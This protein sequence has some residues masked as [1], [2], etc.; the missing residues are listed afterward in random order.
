M[1]AAFMDELEGRV[2]QAAERIAALKKEKGTLEK[3]VADL[4]KKLASAK[5]GA[6]DWEQEREQ[7][8]RRVEGLASKLAEL[9]DE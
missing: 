2:Q 8:R 3:K 5:D 6:A 9:L 4:E 1:S 7:V